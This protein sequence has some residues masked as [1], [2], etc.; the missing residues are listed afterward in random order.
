MVQYIVDGYSFSDEKSYKVAKNEQEGVAYLRKRINYNNAENVRNI[1]DTVIEKGLFKTPVGYEFLKELQGYL[2]EN[3]TIDHNRI[4]PIPVTISGGERKSQKKSWKWFR[5][6]EKEMKKKDAESS[7]Y[8]NRFINMVILN[9]IC[10]IL[11]V[12]FIIIS[13]NSKNVNII[14][15]R[16]RIDA[17]YMEKEDN[18]ARWAEELE[19]RES[20]LK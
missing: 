16:N 11:L 9:V 14:N 13:T 8:R 2:V 1:Y 10:I 20:A 12:L 18:L 5:K 15:Y 17:E 6:K 4:R 3:E 7:P 19:A